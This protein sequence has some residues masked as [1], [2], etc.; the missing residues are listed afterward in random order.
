MK[1]IKVI[2]QGDVVGE[3]L[4]E[5]IEKKLYDEFVYGNSIYSVHSSG[6][7]VE[8]VFYNPTSWAKEYYNN[9]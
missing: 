4:K 7:D 5:T 6:G 1:R 8:I 3:N 9:S 2:E